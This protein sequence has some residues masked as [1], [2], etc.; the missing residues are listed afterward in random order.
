MKIVLQTLLIMS[1]GLN[2]MSM[3]FSGQ[4]SWLHT[5]KFNQPFQQQQQMA[6]IIHQSSV[7]TNQIRK[8]ISHV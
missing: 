3:P 4:N 5:L 6:P 1:I 2:V 7:L 8:H